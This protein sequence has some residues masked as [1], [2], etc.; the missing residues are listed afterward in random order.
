MQTNILCDGDSHTYIALSEDKVYGFIPIQ[1]QQCV[2][3]VKKRMGTA[4]R[5][6]VDENKNKDRELS[7]SGRGRMTHGLKKLTNYY[8]WAIKS[9]PN[10]V[11]AMEKAVMATFHHITSNDDEPHHKHC[12]SGVYSWCNSAAALGEP[13]PPHKLQLPAHVQAA[14]LPIYK[15]L[16]ARELLERGQ[17]GKTQNAIESEQCDFVDPFKSQPSLLFC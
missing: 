8:G 9:N 14:L 6:L 3:H 5:N 12:P 2:N 7:M 16:S 4:L 15:R 11:P 17:Q 10:D 1:E 13:A